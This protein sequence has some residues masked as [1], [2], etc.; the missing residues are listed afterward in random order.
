MSLAFR[1]AS[2]KGIST[3]ASTSTGTPSR[4]AGSNS[5]LPSA[6]SR[7][8]VQTCRPVPEAAPRA[9][10]PP[11][12]PDHGRQPHRPLHAFAAAAGDVLGVHLA[13]RQRTAHAGA[14]RPPCGC[15]LRE[16]HQPA[17]R[18]AGDVRHL[19]GDAVNHPSRK[20]WVGSRAARKALA[21]VGADFDSLA[22]LTRR[23]QILLRGWRTRFASS[24]GCASLAPP[25]TV[26]PGTMTRAP[27]F[28]PCAALLA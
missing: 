16:P 2:R 20:P 22:T 3:T 28:A 5:H 10:H 18:V 4:S 1:G 7:A 19:D 14:P 24:V 25:R 8:A 6:S 15:A 12:R 11:V 27:V 23:Q 17:S 21:S 9:V 13:Q 26:R